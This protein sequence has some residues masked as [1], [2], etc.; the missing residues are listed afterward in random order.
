MGMVLQAEDP[1]LKRT[2]ALKVMRPELAAS[3]DARERFLR[4]AQATAA[5][6]HPHIIH[7]YQV[8][9]DRGV[10]YLAMPFLKG[11]AMD[12][13]LKRKR[14]LSVPEVIALGKQIAEGLSAAHKN[15]LIHRD[16]KPGNI[17]LEP[18]DAERA[19]GS[20]S[21]VKILDFGL[22]RA[23]A[24][25]DVNL[26]KTG[27]ILGTP[28]YMA[29]EQA[30][31]EKVDARCD[32]FSLGAVL[33]RMLTGEMPFKGSDTIAILMAL[34]TEEPRPPSELNANVPANLSALVMRLLAK[35]PNKRPASAR[36]V[37]DELA[38]LG[39]CETRRAEPR[40][41]PVE[42]AHPSPGPSR[43]SARREWGAS[44]PAPLRGSARRKRECFSSAAALARAGREWRG[45]ARWR[46]GS[47]PLVVVRQVLSID[48][49]PRTGGHAGQF[50]RH[51]DGPHRGRALLDRRARAQS[52]GRT[53]ESEHEVIL[54]RPF[55]I[56]MHEVTVGQFATFVKD[57]GYITEAEKSGLGSNR[58]QDD[59]KWVADP[60]TTWRNPGFE[61]S[62][63]GPVVCVS[64]N[65]AWNFC[66][67]L[68]GKEGK[69]YVLP[70][71]AQWEYCCRAGS[72]AKFSFGDDDKDLESHAWFARQFREVPAPR[73]SEKPQPLGFVR[74]ARQ[75]LG[76]DSGLVRQELLS[77]LPARRSALPIPERDGTARWGMVES[78]G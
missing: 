64:R 54:T 43:G 68:T 26:T 4:K 74:H 56:G 46:A 51:E 55:Y 78:R 65:D 63:E 22:A 70:S 52:A 16:I 45:R 66:R 7:V 15:G 3:G 58:L 34:A 28:A 9:E 13:R 39:D 41:G 44:S 62:D 76:V 21:W 37:A 32:L 10:P 53:D 12:V 61:Q 38:A 6:E 24:G 48:E 50:A 8:A 35:D 29:P 33:Y 30:K 49:S 1:M 75:R 27:A 69:N 57:T 25:D 20:F 72:K 73:R 36:V 31:G 71:E 2:V 67:W 23:L 18:R 14:R 42:G 77:Q 59:G 60:K 19:G 17:W 47:V 5:I 11:E 40:E